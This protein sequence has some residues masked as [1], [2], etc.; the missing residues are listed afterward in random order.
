VLNA[1]VSGWAAS[2]LYID[3]DA[4]LIKEGGSIADNF[5]INILKKPDVTELA[6]DKVMI[7]S[8]SGKYYM[9]TGSANDIW[10]MLNQGVESEGIIEN[11]TRIYE[12][13]PHE[14]REGVLRFLSELENI[15]FISL[16]KCN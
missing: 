5:K 12:V 7:D 16:E 13:A 6:G 8:E 10:D 4:D 14:C 3:W 2:G 9:L 15:G 11:L 1:P